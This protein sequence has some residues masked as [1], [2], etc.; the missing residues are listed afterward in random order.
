MRHPE[1]NQFIN[2]P[3]LI[4]VFRIILVAP[5]LYGLAYQLP[6]LTSVAFIAIVLS[7]ILDGAVARRLGEPNAYGT[8]IDHGS[9]AFVVVILC[10]YFSYKG[11]CTWLLPTLIA[12]AFLHYALDSRR[13][14]INAGPRPSALGRANGISYFVF[15]AA[16]IAS[17][18]GREYM[19]ANMG[20]LITST[21][22]VLAWLLVATTC[23]SIWQRRRLSIP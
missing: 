19:S 2:W 22:S 21:I 10:A 8:L 11:L 7:D 5:A 15:V 13:A 12:I 16:C 23:L 20:T 6:I 3:N 17:Y 4:S 9:D 1:F 14:R 18:H